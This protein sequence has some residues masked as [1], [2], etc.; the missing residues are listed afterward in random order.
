[1][2][3]PNFPYNTW[4]KISNVSYATYGQ[5][6]S[7]SYDAKGY[8]SANYNPINQSFVV[9]DG[10]IDDPNYTATIYANSVWE[11]KY[12][13]SANNCL[14]VDSWKNVGTQFATSYYLS[15]YNI[16]DALPSP[17]DRHPSVGYANNRL[18]IAAGLNNNGAFI[19]REFHSSAIN[20]GTSEIT[21]DTTYPYVTGEYV[22]LI[23]SGTLPTPLSASTRYYA[24]RVDET[25]LKLATTYANSVNGTSIT[26]SDSGS[27]QHFIRR[28]SNHPSDIWEFDIKARKWT[29][30]FPLSAYYVDV[31]ALSP[32]LIWIDSIKKMMIHPLRS[33]ESNAQNTYLYDPLTQTFTICGGTNARNGNSPQM[34]YPGSLCYDPIR[35]YVWCFGSGEYGV[36]GA[37]LWTFNPTTKVWVKIN[38]TG[39]TPP[40]RGYH[41]VVYNNKYD[42]LMVYGGTSGDFATGTIMKDTWMYNLSTSAWTQL[43]VGQPID[44][45]EV[46]GVYDFKNDLWIIKSDDH[47]GQTVEWWALRYGWDNKIQKTMRM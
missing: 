40:I 20:V 6:L 12:R 5:Y 22:N 13:T 7:G 8:G 34:H 18:Y 28:E 2:T 42:S 27:G 46:Y 45:R 15:A 44:S 9:W 47:G 32:G 30:H 23:T 1:M 37:E 24:I 3:I 21:L 26:F 10:Y 36:G 38:Q 35:N 31:D 11:F 17:Y 16:L 43:N 39:T 33:Y 4:T 14:Y 25:K 29:Q 19:K 41:S